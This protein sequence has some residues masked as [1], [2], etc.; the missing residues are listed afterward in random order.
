MHK[1]SS[2]EILMAS[3]DGV[4]AFDPA[5][6]QPTRVKTLPVLTSLEVNNS[7]VIGGKLH[8]DKDFALPSDISVL[9][10]LMIDYK[11]NNFTI[12]F[13]AME[14]TAPE[15]NLYRH[16]LE[17]YDND[18]IETD[19]RNRTATYTNLD[20]GE[21][22]FRVTASNHHGIWGDVEKTLKI[23]VLPPPWK[24]TWAYTGYA[25]IFIG[26]LY[27]ARKIVVQ[28]E[29]LKS[30]LKLEKVEREKEHFELEKAKEVDKVKSTFF[31][32]ISHE[33]R[34]PL[35][36]IKGPVQEMLEEYAE[37]PKIK[38][39]MKLVQ[40]NADLV[41]KL[42]NQLLDLAKL[43]SGTLSVEKTESDLNSFLS[44]VTNSFSSLAFQKNIQLSVELPSKRYQA[45]FDKDKME[46]ILINLINNAIK[47]TPP[48]GVVTVNTVLTT[49]ED[50]TQLQSAG[51]LSGGEGRGEALT[52]TVS[53]TGIGIPHDQQT[54]IFE[55][56]HQVSEAHKEVGT[57]IG[58]SLVKELVALMKGTLFY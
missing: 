54:K 24:S 57:G 9:E 49:H 53:D 39:R 32:N 58:L 17:G 56:F 36:L 12:E 46:T 38:E 22:T 29:R 1:T 48:G 23:K 30:N 21:Y 55:R 3:V 4:T 34:T 6:F 31:A 27:A 40:R 16:K 25:I 19:F 20:A 41:L 37:H 35:T 7:P 13:S 42:I 52:L 51:T 33:F 18:W 50:T 10:E 45:R 11:H 47:F 2:G 15:K 8:G 28:R 44:V 5:K 43:E 14:M 26:L